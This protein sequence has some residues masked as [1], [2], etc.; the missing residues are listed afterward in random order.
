MAGA[1]VDVQGTSEDTSGSYAAELEARIKQLEEK[2]ERIRMH[3]CRR[4]L[5]L[6]PVP[7]I[8]D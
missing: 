3:E 4:Q 5:G 1:N 6:V 7:M 2:L 8:E